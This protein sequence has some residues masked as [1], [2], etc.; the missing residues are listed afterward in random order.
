M[1]HE[2]Q[3]TPQNSEC[4]Q[5]ITGEILFLK[6]RW[7]CMGKMEESLKK[8]KT[9]PSRGQGSTGS[10]WKSKVC[11]NLSRSWTEIQVEREAHDF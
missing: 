5:V 3:E 9:E 11:F 4:T 10:D 1:K 6:S 2:T 7:E 8:S